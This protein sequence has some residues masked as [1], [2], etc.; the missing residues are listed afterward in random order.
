VLNISAIKEESQ[1]NTENIK[2]DMA[3]RIEK[4]VSMIEDLLQDKKNLQS[5]IEELVAN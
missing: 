3:D 1:R 2:Q 5:K 4:Q